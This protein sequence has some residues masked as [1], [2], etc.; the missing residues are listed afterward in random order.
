MPLAGGSQE[1]PPLLAAAPHLSRDC[2]R[3]RPILHDVQEPVGE[4]VRTSQTR[5]RRWVGAYARVKR[6]GWGRS[7]VVRERSVRELCKSHCVCRTVDSAVAAVGVKI[8]NKTT[9]NDSHVIWGL[10]ALFTRLKI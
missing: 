7:T 8:C 1:E 9:S 10:D 3:R 6:L 2:G 4:V 5:M